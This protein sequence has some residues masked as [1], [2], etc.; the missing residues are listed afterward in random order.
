MTLRKTSILLVLCALAAAVGGHA[1]GLFPTHSETTDQPLTLYGS[2]DLREVALAF[3]Q[4]GRLAEVTVEEGQRVA[5]GDPVATLDRE[6]FVEAM[7]TAEARVELARVRLE[8]LERGSRPQEIEQARA[9]V[10]EAEARVES[11]RRELDRKRGLVVSG[12]SSQREV[13]SAEEHFATAEARLAAAREALDLVT[14]GFRT[15]DI[16]AGRAELRLAEAELEQVRTALDDTRLLAPSPGIVMTRVREPGA[17]VGAGS[18][19]ASLTLHEPV[20]VRAY[21]DGPHLG[22]VPP[23]TAVTVTSDSS[24][25]A[26]RGHVGFVSPQAEFT[27]KSV[28][29]PELRTD[30]VYRLRILVDDADASLLQGMPVTVGVLEDTAHVLEEGRNPSEARHD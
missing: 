24:P 27:P 9:S 3:R 19:I 1:L 14:E 7:A 12:A 6:P 26:Y 21:V 16:D 13:E 5:A 29:T 2:V 4:G 8:R 17:L 18:T 10:T 30:L 22:K 23:G 28:E 15:E 11:A 25:K 20:V